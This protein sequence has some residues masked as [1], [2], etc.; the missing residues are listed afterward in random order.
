MATYKVRGTS[1][2]VIYPYQTE[3]GAKKQQWE[4]YE[5]EL[6]AIQRKA[7]IDFLQK[8][9][10]HDDIRKAVLE[11]KKARAIA[12][13]AAK[14]LQT[15]T[16]GEDTPAVPAQED[17]TYRTYREFMEKFLPFYARKKR[18]SP[19]TYDSYTSNLS[20]HIYPYFGDRVMSTIT[21]EDIDNFL[22]HLSRKPCQGSKSYGK[23]GDEIPRLSSASIKKCYNVLMVGFPTAKK[24]HYITEIPDT[25]PPA[26]KTKKRLA[27]EP[28]KIFE[29]LDGLKSDPILHLAVHL[30]FVCSLRAAEIAGIEIS[31]IDFHD[32]SLWITQ[33]VQR[34]SDKSLQVL[35][36]EEIVRVF[37]K[38]VA[39]AKSSLILKSP[40]TDGSTRKQ[41]LTTPLLQE[42]K[43]RLAE[44]ESNKAFFGKEY[45]DYGLLFCQP[46]GRPIDPKS[47]NSAFK[48]WQRSMNIETPIELQ[49]L[50]K[51]GQ[52]HKVRLTSNNYQLVAENSGQSPQV[53][54]S[55]YNEALDSEK[56]TLSLL[57]E[58]SFYPKSAS[59]SASDPSTQQDLDILLKKVKQDPVLYQQL[60]QLMLA[61]AAG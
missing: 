16:P 27:W 10:R 18:F 35:P 48:D 20:N 21:A 28:D 25:T 53:L 14:S 36:K 23:R 17:N 50:R 31:T 4:S 45:H 3:T 22:D 30:A 49:G 60:L 57:V 19:N 59:D 12:A 51:S 13:S 33:I 6:E 24:W 46:D 54:M 9:K 56:R 61:G 55:N 1:H 44:I 41:Y 47:F 37:P 29:A 5:T 32:R 7:Y 26:E 2:N 8:N 40:K 58:T 38:Q 42:L 39:R 15:L 11:Y 34:V 43:Q 52:M